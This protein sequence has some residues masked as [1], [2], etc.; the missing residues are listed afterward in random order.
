VLFKELDWSYHLA[1]LSLGFIFKEVD[2]WRRKILFSSRKL[3]FKKLGWGYHLIAFSLGKL[4]PKELNLKKLPIFN[5]AFF[6]ED[7]QE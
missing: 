6:E 1:P 4:L 5:H 7:F 3:I 2:F